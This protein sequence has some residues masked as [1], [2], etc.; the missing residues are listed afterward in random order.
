MRR[1][2][3]TKP[4]GNLLKS[5]FGNCATIDPF[6]RQGNISARLP[7]MTRKSHSKQGK[8]WVNTYPLWDTHVIEHYEQKPLRMA[9]VRLEKSGKS[10]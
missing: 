6:E 9:N 7:L 5:L 4:R 3:E 10:Q 2:L 1:Q 8:P